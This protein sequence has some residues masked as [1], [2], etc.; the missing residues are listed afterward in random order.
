V[1]RKWRIGTTYDYASST[2]AFRSDLRLDE[3]RHLVFA[4]LDYAPTRAWT[5]EAGAGSILGGSLSRS[6]ERHDFSPGLFL[7]LGAAYRLVDGGGAVPFVVLTGQLSY[8]QSR[9]RGAGGSA[10]YGALDLRVGA[11]AGW[12][13]LGVLRPYLLARA[14]GGPVFWNHQGESVTGTDTHHYQ[15]GGGAVVTIARRVDLHAEGV[16]LGERGIS[17]GAGILF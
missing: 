3:A 4:T 1:R 11:L 5:L 12:A 6:S 2:I 13:V 10:G 17:A 8:L 9:T 15:L 16:P 7:G 14:F